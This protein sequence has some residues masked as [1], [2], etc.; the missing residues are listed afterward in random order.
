MTS[1]AA[2]R[3]SSAEGD[4][5]PHAAAAAADAAADTDDDDDADADATDGGEDDSDVKDLLSA[6][7]KTSLVCVSAPSR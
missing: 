7:V 1:S 2:S 5:G 4:A 3:E 6:G